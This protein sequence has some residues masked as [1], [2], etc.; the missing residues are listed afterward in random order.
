MTYKV[1]DQD[2][3]DLFELTKALKTL[4]KF[5]IDN[6]SVKNDIEAEKTK[7]KNKIKNK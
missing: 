4:E 3:K 1:P 5:G 2:E 6:Q 7:V